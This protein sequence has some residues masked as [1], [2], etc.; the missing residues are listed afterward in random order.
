MCKTMNSD[1]IEK[2][3]PLDFEDL[4]V[5][6][7][8]VINIFN[9]LPDKWNGMAGTYEGKDLHNLPVI[10]KLFLVD[11]ED[12]LLY[13]DLLSVIIEDKIKSINKKMGEKQRGKQKTNKRV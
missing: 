13:T 9:Y 3:M 7:Q 12:W 4:T 10:L 6:S 8:E 2:E 1:P 5:Q 11:R